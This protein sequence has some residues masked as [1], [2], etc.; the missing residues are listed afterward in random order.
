MGNTNYLIDS[1][2]LL[3][4]MVNPRRLS[5]KARKIISNMDESIYASAATTYELAYKFHR[6]KLPGYDRVF[7]GYEH[8]VRR[9]AQ[10]TIS[11]TSEHA[12][13]AA[14]LEWEH[15]DPFDR[16]IAAQA[17]I[18]GATLITA[19]TAMQRFEPLSTVW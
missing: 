3:F 13:A 9:I 12:L 8:H 10:W 6:G 2:V 15:G 7:V 14:G 19:D 18:E 11:I 5:P 4:A 16:L 1:Q 17:M